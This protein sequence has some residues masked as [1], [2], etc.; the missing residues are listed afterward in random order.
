[1]VKLALAILTDRNGVLNVDLPVSG[2][3]DDP[4]FSFGRMI[5]SALEN[6]L[7]KV[8]T[9]PFALIGSLIGSNEDLSSV[10]FAAG[11]S[12]LEAGEVEKLRKLGKVLFDR[13]ALKVEIEGKVDARA[14]GEALRRQKLDLRLAP[15]R[16][17]PLGPQER[18]KLIRAEWT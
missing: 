9:S 14:D 1:P 4:S 6:L 3:L 13:P 2:D 10:S 17:T 11:S 12:D 8:A 7:L 5:W 18:E 15:G 16:K